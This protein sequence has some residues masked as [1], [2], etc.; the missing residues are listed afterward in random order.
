M[1]RVD[2]WLGLGLDG[3]ILF[4]FFALWILLDSWAIIWREGFWAKP[5]GY[6]AKLS[7]SYVRCLL[8]VFGLLAAFLVGVSG[9]LHLIPV[10]VLL[11]Q[12]GLQD[13]GYWFL[14]TTLFRKDWSFTGP[15]GTRKILGIPYPRWW[16]WLDAMPILKWRSGGRVS[17]WGIVRALLFGLATS[18]VWLLWI[19][20]IL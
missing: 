2:G 16:P 15:D 7:K 6:D 19:N 1:Q 18:A 17:F 13:L 5:G 12:C 10:F 4:W 3:L 8:T 20:Y 9:R 11:Q 14:G